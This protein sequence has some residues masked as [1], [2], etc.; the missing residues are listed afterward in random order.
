MNHW[1]LSAAL[2]SVFLATG[3]QAD[4]IRL[5]LAQTE[6]RLYPS[7][8]D[9]AAHMARQMQAAMA[10]QPDLVVFP[11]DIGLPL[12]LVDDYAVVKDCRT[13]RQAIVSLVRAHAAEVNPLT[14]QGMTVSQAL[15]RFKSARTQALYRKTFGG[16]ARRHGVYV[17]A[18][19]A[20]LPWQGKVANA[21]YLFS[22]TG[23]VVGTVGKAHLV[24]L[25]GPEGLSLQPV[26]GQRPWQTPWGK[27]SMIICADAWDAELAASHWSQGARLLLNC[28]ANPE[29]WSEAQQAGM[30]GGSLPARV[31]ETGLPGAQCYA[32]GGLFDLRFHGKS[33]L[34][35][36]LPGNKWEALARAQTANKEEIVAGELDLAVSDSQ[37]IDG[38]TP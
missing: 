24:P 27:L 11:E 37:P 2:L 16:L 36:A 30:D 10:T 29:P 23:E 33:Q 20:P 18:G 12:V 8:G 7:A 17:A 22:P 31:A 32:V 15:L 38:D 13:T 34:L 26:T 4:R 21:S 35:R 6:L 5:A 9:Y 1:L 3:S 19:S 25:E 28:L 14:D